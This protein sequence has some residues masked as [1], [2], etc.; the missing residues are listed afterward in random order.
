MQSKDSYRTLVILLVLA[1]LCAWTVMAELTNAR[2][3]NGYC[4]DDAYIAFTYAKNFNNEKGL[5]FHAGE[6]VEGYTNFLWLI[7]LAPWMKWLPTVDVSTI[8]IFWGACFSVAVL[9]LTYLL[10]YQERKHHWTNLVAPLL[11]SLDNT[12]H[13]WSVSGLENAMQT[14][15]VLLAFLFLFGNRKRSAL[16]S[17][18]AFAIATMTRPDSGVFWAVAIAALLLRALRPGGTGFSLKDL[19]QL[20]GGFLLIL[21]PYGAWKIYYYGDLLPNTFYLHTGDRGVRIAK[22]SAYLF[23]FLENRFYLPLLGALALLAGYSFR[24]AVLL[25]SVLGFCFYTVWIGGD[26]F[27]GSRFYYVILPLIYLL[28]QDAAAW[29]AQSGGLKTAV[30]SAAACLLAGALIFTGSYGPRGEYQDFVLTW[31]RDDLQRIQ[32]AK[33]FS[34]VAKEGDSILSGPV[35]QIAYYSGMKV[36]DYWG[37]TDPHIARST[38]ATISENVP[39]H[40]RTDLEYLLNQKPVYIIFGVDPKHPPAGYALH[41]FHVDNRRWVVLKRIE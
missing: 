5:V 4:N 27:P 15:L 40:E 16:F 28:M 21:V 34:R 12:F 14:A 31:A 7:F 24:R 41:E 11:L 20:S 10:G 30:S 8:A 22:G 25:L 32:L 29:I 36:L 38:A 3:F 19:L 37:V 9:I 39:G 33:D 26:F 35:G 13:Y 1:L 18:I 2:A 17:G 23:R 6:R